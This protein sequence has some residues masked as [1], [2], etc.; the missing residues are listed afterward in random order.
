M[1]N[2]LLGGYLEGLSDPL[3]AHHCEIKDYRTVGRWRRG[4]HFPQP[5]LWGKLAFLLGRSV[6]DIEAAHAAY[7]HGLDESTPGGGGESD[8]THARSED[9]GGGGPDGRLSRSGQGREPADV[10]AQ[11]DQ[12]EQ[13]RDTER[14]GAARRQGAGS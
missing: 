5:R 9:G 3:V 7:K 14:A 12:G 4:E 10:G 11:V 13:A 6:K 2:N 8:G 1:R